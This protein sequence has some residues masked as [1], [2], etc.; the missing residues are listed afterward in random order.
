MSVKKGEIDIVAKTKVSVTSDT[1]VDVFAPVVKAGDAEAT[2]L[3]LA[4]AYNDLLTAL[5]TFASALAA[6][7][8]PPLTPVGTAG[9]NLV[10]ALGLLPPPATTKLLGT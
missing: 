7:S 4:T 10:T 1:E 2:A 3:V 6:L 9:T 8:S 5:G